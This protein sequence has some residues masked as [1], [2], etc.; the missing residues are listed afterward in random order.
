MRPKFDRANV[1]WFD[2][3]GI[4]RRYDEQEDKW[5]YFIR[6]INGYG[7][8]TDYFWILDWGTHFPAEVGTL[9]FDNY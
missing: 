2:K 1:R 5:F 6:N 4:A 7:E 3:V 8:E 9:L